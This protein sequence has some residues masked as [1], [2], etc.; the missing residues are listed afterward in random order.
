MRLEDRTR[1]YRIWMAMRNCCNNTKGPRFYRY[2]GRGIKVCKRWNSFKLFLV[3]MGLCPTSK[4]SIE[5]RNNN[6]GYNPKNCYWGTSHEQS[7]NSSR[8]KKITYQGE[9]LVIKDWAA[10]LS[11]K[12]TTLWYRIRVGW[13]VQLAFTMKPST[14]NR[15]AQ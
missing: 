3:D 8:N 13:P 15:L 11:I 10:K 2:G 14:T 9:T 12:Y 1:E 7:R 4:H 6:L 5:R